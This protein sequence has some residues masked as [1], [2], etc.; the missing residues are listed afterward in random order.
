MRS[1]RIRT[2][3]PSLCF[4]AFSRWIT[5]STSRGKR[6]SGLRFG[7]LHP[8][9]LV[10]QTGM[11]ISKAKNTAKSPVGATRWRVG[12]VCFLKNTPVARD[13]FTSKTELAPYRGKGRAESNP[14]GF[15]YINYYTKRVKDYFLWYNRRANWLI[16]LQS[17]LWVRDLTQTKPCL[18][19]KEHQRFGHK[20][21]TDLCAIAH[22]RI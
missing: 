7:P 10:Q 19:I 6:F 14:N 22:Y 8:D 21:Q 17:C 2:H 1:G 12:T 16:P 3:A 4:V 5:G 20:L 18:D 13:R 11:K 9:L 15:A